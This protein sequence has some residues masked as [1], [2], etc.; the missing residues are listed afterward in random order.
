MFEETYFMKELKE[1]PAEL[2]D[3]IV[4]T[5]RGLVFV[6]FLRLKKSTV[7]KTAIPIKSRIVVERSIFPPRPSAGKTHLRKKSTPPNSK[8]DFWATFMAGLRRMLW[9]VS[10]ELRENSLIPTWPCLS[11]VMVERRN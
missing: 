4:K 6:T 7:P 2:K 10:R 3:L 9:N 11:R 8:T 1:P 5:E